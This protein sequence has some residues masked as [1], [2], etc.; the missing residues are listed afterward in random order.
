LCGLIFYDLSDNVQWRVMF[1]C[2]CI[3]PI[4]VIILSQKVM[5]ESPR[6][7]VSKGRDEEAKGILA[8][9]YPEGKKINVTLTSL[10]LSHRGLRVCVCVAPNYVLIPDLCPNALQQ[11]S[12]ST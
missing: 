10:L 5:A 3:L 4:G 11:V 2:G 6:F 12:T 8:K 1:S 7:L 9:I